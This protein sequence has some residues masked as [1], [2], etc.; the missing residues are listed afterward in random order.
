MS[1]GAGKDN[2]GKM[3]LTAGT[4][5]GVAALV[6][7]LL[8]PRPVEAAP[9]G[10]RWEDLLEAQAAIILLLEQQIAAIEGLS[11]AISVK[12]PWIAK[13]PEQIY[14]HAIRVIGVFTSD[15]MIDWVEG[16]RLLI[17]VESTLNQ[18]CIIQLIGNFVDDMNLASDINGPINVAADENHSIG[19]AWDDWH[20]FIG[21]RITTA[22]AP[23]AGIL[24]IWSVIQE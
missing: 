7:K 15:K 12:T 20:P 18:A 23:G 8:T 16:K 4:A 5:G 9:P 14:S 13:T 6:A 1:N 21:V 11:I 24:N 3:I 17:K 2:V 19:L 10:E 22:I